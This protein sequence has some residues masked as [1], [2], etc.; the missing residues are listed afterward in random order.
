MCV[1]IKPM[2]VQDLINQLS[3]FDPETPILCQSTDPSDYTYKT[4]IK[5]IELGNPFDDNGFSGLD[6]SEMDWEECYEEDEETG[7]DFYIGPKV[8]IINLGTV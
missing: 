4:P 3:S 8:V 1:K 5:S 2:I 7:E 6:D